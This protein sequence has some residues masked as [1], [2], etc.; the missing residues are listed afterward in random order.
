[1]YHFVF[2]MMLVRKIQ[3]SLKSTK[4]A[5]LRF[6]AIM[7]TAL[8]IQGVVYLTLRML[9]EAGNTFNTF[10]TTV[11]IASSSFKLLLDGTVFYIFIMNMVFFIGRKQACLK[12]EA[13]R[14]SP[15]NKFIMISIGFMF[16]MQ[17]LGTAFNFSNAV[18]S[19]I[20]KIYKSQGYIDYRLI[21]GDIVFPLRDFIDVMFFSYLFYFQ[22]KK[23]V[24]LKS[25]NIE[26][27]TKMSDQQIQ[28]STESEEFVP[29]DEIEK[30]MRKETEDYQFRRFLYQQIV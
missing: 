13:L 20:D 2:E 14:F 12:R 18:I 5:T 24:D 4:E 22:S 16:L 1:M 11:F 9:I 17:I 3:T 7:I 6:K 15:F 28:K 29:E 23:R 27:L 10:V 19:L 8:F 25:V 26:Y 21:M 30:I